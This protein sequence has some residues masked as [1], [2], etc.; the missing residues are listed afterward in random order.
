MTSRCARRMLRDA[1]LCC[2]CCSAAVLSARRTERDSAAAGER[3]GTVVQALRRT[4]PQI[5]EES[6]AHTT[7]RSTHNARHARLA[8]AAAATRLSMVSKSVVQHRA[9][10]AIRRHDVFNCESNESPFKR[11]E[12]GSI[13]ELGARKRK[14]TFCAAGAMS[15]PSLLA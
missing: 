6:A 1:A 10:A 14:G 3:R 11:C 7:Q 2:G 12:F 8:A 15:E 5:R 4:G 9:G 13:V